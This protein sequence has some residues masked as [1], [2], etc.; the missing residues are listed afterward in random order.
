MLRLRDNL[1]LDNGVWREYYG[2]SETEKSLTSYLSRKKFTEFCALDADGRKK[3]LK[4]LERREKMFPFVG[5][6]IFL[7]KLTISLLLCAVIVFFPSRIDIRLFRQSGGV[8]LT[9]LILSAIAI[10]AGIFIL[11]NNVE[12]YGIRRRR[13]LV[14]VYIAM[15]VGFAFLIFVGLYNLRIFNKRI[16]SPAY[17]EEHVAMGYFRSFLQIDVGIVGLVSLVRELKKIFRFSCKYCNLINVL[18]MKNISHSE[19]VHHHTHYESGGYRESETEFKPVGSLFTT[20]TAKTRTYVPGHTVYDGQYQHS[21]YTT[22]YCC[23]RCGKT[24]KSIYD[25]YEYKI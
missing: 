9:E 16:G 14:I 10:P 12:N 22:T 20:Y 15:A 6:L 18:V 2:L 25:H 5:F 3:V 7:L 17:T 4:T 24:E 13:L 21:D 19:S 23:P 1:K 8:M 11:K